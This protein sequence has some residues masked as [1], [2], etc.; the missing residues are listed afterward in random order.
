MLI[1]FLPVFL[2]FLIITLYDVTHVSTYVRVTCRLNKWCIQIPQ[3]TIWHCIEKM[4]AEPAEGQPGDNLDSGFNDAPTYEQVEGCVYTLTD[5][6]EL[7]F[8]MYAT[9]SGDVVT[10]YSPGFSGKMVK[11]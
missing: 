11:Q 7:A 8:D 2:F 4:V 6:F 9:P 3:R 1:W 5:G 10:Y